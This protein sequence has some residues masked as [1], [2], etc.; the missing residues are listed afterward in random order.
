MI[1]DDIAKDE[2]YINAS[3]E[4][5]MQ[6]QDKFFDGYI[7]PKATE[8]GLDLDTVRSEFKKRISAPMP[9]GQ[10]APVAVENGQE[11][12]N[13]LANALFTPE[14][15]QELRNKGPIDFWESFNYVTEKDIPVYGLYPQGKELGRLYAIKKLMDEGKTIDEIGDD[16]KEFVLGY[17]RKEVEK[18]IRGFTIGGDIVRGVSSMPSFLVEFALAA[19][20]LGAIPAA[21]T[22]IKEGVKE[23]AEKAT[24]KSIIKSVGKYSAVAPLLMP[25]TYSNTA[26][27]NIMSGI[28]IT[29]KGEMIIKE[30]ESPIK[31]A[32]MAYAGNSIEFGTELLGVG[33][34]K[35]VSPLMRSATNALPETIKLALYKGLQM[36]KPNTRVSDILSR[37]GWNGFLIEYGEEELAR[38]LNAGLSYIG[39][40]ITAEEALEQ[41]K[42]NTHD[43]LVTAGVLG[44]AQGVST[45]SSMTI[46]HFMKKG[47]TKEQATEISNN[48]TELEKDKLTIENYPDPKGSYTSVVKDTQKIMQADREAVA[49]Q[50]DIWPD[51]EEIYKSK[52]Y[53]DIKNTAEKVAA[54][55]GYRLKNVSINR[56][57]GISA[58]IETPIGDIRISD[59]STNYFIGALNTFS[60]DVNK[61]V[62]YF[63]EI[64]EIRKDKEQK[65]KI[66]DDAIKKIKEQFTTQE[67]K[68]IAKS[69]VLS[70]IILKPHSGYLTQSFRGESADIIRRWKEGD[71]SILAPFSK[72]ETY[73]TSETMQKMEEGKRLDEL[74]PAYKGETIQVNNIERSVYNSNGE[75]INQSAE[76]LTNFW[77][78]F[79]DS[80][81]VDEQGRPLV[82]YH[83]T[84]AD[85]DEFKTTKSFRTGFGGA[86]REVYSPSFFFTP[87]KQQ[88]T[89]FA[90]DR[91]GSRIKYNVKEIYLNLR[92]PLDLSNKDAKK[93]AK[94][95]GL[96]DRFGDIPNKNEMW[97]IFDEPN[98][99]EILKKSGYDGAIISEKNAAKSFNNTKDKFASQTFAAFN[100]NQ[101]KSVEN[102]GTYGSSANIYEDREYTIQEGINEVITQEQNELN[103]PTVENDN[104]SFSEVFDKGIKDFV[105]QYVNSKKTLES[106]S[107]E[108]KV[109]IRDFYGI[110]GT[111]KQFLST[112]IW[113]EK[114]NRLVVTGKSLQHILDDFDNTVMHIEGDKTARLQDFNDFLI[115]TRYEELLG[116]EDVKVTEEQKAQTLETLA[117]LE[118]KY[119]DKLAWF[120]QYAQELYTFQKNIL[121]RLVESGNMSEE[122]YNE[123]VKNNKKYIPF[124]RVFEDEPAFPVST[125]GKFTKAKS[126]IKKIRGSEREIKNVLQSITENT[127][128]IITI[129]ERNRIA[130]MISD[131]LVQVGEAT[132]VPPQ[133]V[134]KGTAKVKITYDKGLS[135]LLDK[136]IE[137]LGGQY[138]QVKTINR[139][140]KIRGV[141]LPLENKILERIGTHNAKA[142]EFGHMLDSVLG[143]GGKILTKDTRKEL[144][145]LA[146]ERLVNGITVKGEKGENIRLERDYMDTYASYKEYINSPEELVA[147]F[148]D[149]Y[150]TA[151]QLAREIAPKTSKLMDDF[152]NTT[153]KTWL[154]DIRPTLQKGTEEIE[155]DVWGASPFAPKETITVYE[156]GK[157]QF[158]KVENED[159]LREIEN[160]DDYINNF[161]TKLLAAPTTILRKG[162]T[163]YN[164]EFI[165]RNPLRDIQQ[166]VIQS[167]LYDINNVW[168]VP[169]QFIK[170]L[171]DVVKATDLYNERMA[172]GGM[173]ETLM[174][175]DDKGTAKNFSEFYTEVFNPK[176][177]MFAKINPFHWVSVLGQVGEQTTRQMIFNEAINQGYGA[178]EAAMMSRDTIDFAVSGKTGKSLN[179][180]IPFLNAGIRGTA[181]MFGKW[182]ENPRLFLRKALVGQTIPAILLTGYYLYYAD[183]DER[184]EFLNLPDWRRHL[185]FNFKIGDV[186]WAFPKA[187]AIG[188]IFATPFEFAMIANYDGEKPESKNLFMETVGGILGSVSPIQDIGSSIPVLFKWAIEETANYN[189]FTGRNIFPTYLERYTPSEQYNKNTPD[190]LKEI[191]K[192]TDISPARLEH[193]IRSFTGGSGML[194]VS[195]AD[196]MLQE[197]KKFNGERVPEAPEDLKNVPVI[198]GFIASYP[199][200]SS[201]KEVQNFYENLKEYQQIEATSKKKEGKERQ[202]YKRENRQAI[203]NAQILKRANDKIKTIRKNIDKIKDN[204][205]MSGKDKVERIRKLETQ[206]TDVARIANHMIKGE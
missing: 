37:I 49:I 119:G 183:D 29:D 206:M 64:L 180:F 193:T 67:I 161:I 45:A 63:N 198:R 28:D 158:Y 68:D 91:S 187:F 7:A 17:L 86:K 150:V 125:K 111:I 13:Q 152:L 39:S 12:T 182:K 71:L 33:I 156:N 50:E 52:E 167:E 61:I 130:K 101:I 89:D 144:E 148:Y 78:W 143:L 41:I 155:Q 163:E 2:R 92:N 43:R 25:S 46:N 205:T 18:D 55:L 176:G 8:K 137:L 121:H 149:A 116:R 178:K 14:K 73:V 82:V 115:A 141:Y 181:T 154:K 157:R 30:S 10:P 201:S 133:M 53:Q 57:G 134:K 131:A 109:S 190:I 132:P 22:A 100:P 117:R 123:I 99:I 171:F 107:P 87:S 19:G 122:Q 153:D 34:S 142:H 173:F 159:A 168:K 88:A 139:S 93:I 35:A 77:N 147:N 202:E 113:E 76:A 164:P 69:N 188:E 120:E 166:A 146:Q 58:Y 189:F 172:A 186:W 103:P 136:G 32:L 83:G 199:M 16:N 185:F 48:M 74:F 72:P 31:S 15:I 138:Q 3:P 184:N 177:K 20:S 21:K 196:K 65:V 26:Q 98:N 36:I 24:A 75:R 4:L 5:Q 145:N 165:F 102:K 160:T 128:R 110:A 135:E 59:H 200:G 127:A 56:N 84:N 192:V 105:F 151:P 108:I 11:T 81:V 194:V 80:K 179:R 126:P 195:G 104:S 96:K 162:A 95:L 70:T 60:K 94:S 42:G 170:S 169:G 23:T 44:I 112:G 54:K 1:W 47:Y 197:F 62:S 90:I 106:L 114:D 27:R 38:I 6:M 79:G 175:Q 129:S 204:V 124:Q 191:G 174:A 140:S 66:F 85:F 118:N 51:Y 97:E 203:S 40:D 9:Q